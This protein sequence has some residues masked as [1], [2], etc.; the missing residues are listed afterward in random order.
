MR[1]AIL[2]SQRGHPL[3]RRAVSAGAG[4]GLASCS[5]SSIAS[6]S[7]SI[8]ATSHH[9]QLHRRQ[10]HQRASSAS[11]PSSSSSYLAF[12]AYAYS[13][14][15]PS[16][17][18]PFSPRRT[19]ATE[20]NH[21]P[22]KSG[23]ENK[24]QAEKQADADA[25][26]KKNSSPSK[27]SAD[28]QQAKPSATIPGLEAFFGGKLGQRPTSQNNPSDSNASSGGKTKKGSGFPFELGQD[29][30]KDTE[31]EHLNKSSSS[32]NG[33]GSSGSGGPPQ[34]PQGLAPYLFPLAALILFHFI[35]NGDSSSR[36]ITWQE[37][38]TAFLDKGLV[39]K[40]TVVNRSKVRVHLH[41]NA[42]GVLYPQSPAADGRSTYYFSIGSVEAFER[43]LDEAQAELGIPG[44]ERVP[45]AYKEETSIGSTLLSF[46]PTL[47][48]VGVLYFISRRAGGAG[49]A[50]GPGGIFGVGKSKAKMFNVSNGTSVIAKI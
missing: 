20:S 22:Q 25:K 44:S 24:E 7:T 8:A 33:K 41:S 17:L 28:Q 48:I 2:C 9:Q 6:S 27:K 16:A 35:T 3:Q 46:A 32:G 21:Q 11:T 47:L 43:K 10:L 4:A 37:F 45:V 13:Y 1:R 18:S 29:S 15:H 23:K 42:T 5:G 26:L 40:L 12:S 14:S 34:G 50:G 31:A 19:Y 49:G 38:R 36:E 39:D 30:G